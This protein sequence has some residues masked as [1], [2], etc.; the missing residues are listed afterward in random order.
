M[1]S[2]ILPEFELMLPQSVPEA[3]ALLDRYQERVTVLTQS[4]ESEEA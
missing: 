2:R 4:A 3:V 1:S